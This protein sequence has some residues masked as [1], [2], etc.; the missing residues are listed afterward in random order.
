MV[1]SLGQTISQWKYTIVLNT[2]F[3]STDQ[4]N[5]NSK[6]GIN[7]LILIKRWYIFSAK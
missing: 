4:T 2:S 6:V 3:L 5:L 1:S 7:I